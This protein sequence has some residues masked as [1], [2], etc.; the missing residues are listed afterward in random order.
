MA[1]RSI[2]G[3]SR[4]AKSIQLRVDRV[5]AQLQD[6]LMAAPSSDH[7]NTLLKRLY[8]S[9][10]SGDVTAW[11]Q[12]LAE[13][14]VFIGTDEAEFRQGKDQIIPLVRAQL[15]EMSKSGMR[16]TAGTPS[17]VADGGVVWAIDR[18]TLRLGDGTTVPVRMTV[19]ASQHD[20][21]LAVRH[22]H[23]SVGAPNE[24]VVHETLTI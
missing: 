16:F 12:S 6:A 15:A 1:G 18:P 17:L 3:L 23:V 8:D 24:E 10:E 4:L 11:E 20:S 19:L 2:S 9:V 14:A 22:I 5:T 7:M 21:G 13:D